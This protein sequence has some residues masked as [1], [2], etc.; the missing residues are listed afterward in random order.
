[1][2]KEERI[3][4]M[5]GKNL[6]EELKKSEANYR[7]ILYAPSK[8]IQKKEKKFLEEL[9]TLEQKEPAKILRVSSVILEKFSPIAA[10]QGI[11]VVAERFSHN[12]Q[13]I[14][15]KEKLLILVDVQDPG[16]LGTIIRIAESNDAGVVLT[17]GSASPFNEK[18]VRASMG[19][20]L[21]VP[22]ITVL[23][24]IEI[25]NELKSKGFKI[26]AATTSGEKPFWEIDYTKKAAILLGNEGHGTGE[27]IMKIA[28]YQVYIP[29]K[30][31]VESY[32]VAISAAIL[33]CP[34]L[35][36]EE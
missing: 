3:F 22:F 25:I 8:L 18:S 24:L 21:R 11:L 12:L 5:L 9:E 15:K 2:A 13:N 31:R 32:N 36:E 29:M 33:L 1:M 6:Y 27:E 4:F 14:L 23:N 17:K 10:D 16:N 30:G 7:Y 26:Y 28:D 35:M 34:G 20:V 19:S